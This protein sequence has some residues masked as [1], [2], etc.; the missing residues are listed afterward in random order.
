MVYLLKMVY[1]YQYLMV[2]MLWSYQPA[3]IRF[4][5]W[6]HRQ[7]KAS[8]PRWSSSEKLVPP[9]PQRGPSDTSET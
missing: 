4:A 1:L 3:A 5:V 6:V 8:A 9:H 2:M 7:E